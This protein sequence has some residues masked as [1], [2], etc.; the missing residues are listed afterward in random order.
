MK[1]ENL[2]LGNGTVP[3]TVV[4]HC[5]SDE[6]IGE[7]SRAELLISGKAKACSDSTRSVTPS[8]PKIKKIVSAFIYN[9]YYVH[10]MFR[11][12]KKQNDL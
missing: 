9:K 3:I 12:T 6:A 5:T 1:T 10:S 11:Y 4:S 2:T 8:I 7:Q